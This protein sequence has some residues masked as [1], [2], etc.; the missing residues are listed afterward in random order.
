MNFDKLDIFFVIFISVLI[1]SINK[2]IFS[3]S[4]QIPKDNK[5]NLVINEYK[6]KN[7]DGAHR[8]NLMIPNNMSHDSPDY[9]NIGYIYTPTIRYKL[10]GKETYNRSHKYDYFIIDDNKIKI[11]VQQKLNKDCPCDEIQDGDTVYI[12]TL[13]TDNYIAKIYSYTNNYNPFL[14]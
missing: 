5:I 6:H 4:Q 11:A 8:T 1:F 9:E 13:N 2:Y 12:P 3:I 14:I 7:I 10:Y